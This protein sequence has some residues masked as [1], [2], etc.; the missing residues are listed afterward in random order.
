MSDHDSKLLY[1]LEQR[2]LELERL[3]DKLMYLNKENHA[4]VSQRIKK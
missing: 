4:T 1:D 2:V 3:L